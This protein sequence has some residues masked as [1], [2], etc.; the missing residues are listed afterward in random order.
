MSLSKNSCQWAVHTRKTVFCWILCTSEFASWFYLF[1][2]DIWSCFSTVD[3]TEKA[4]NQSTWIFLYVIADIHTITSLTYASS[5]SNAPCLFFTVEGHTGTCVLKIQKVFQ[6]LN[7]APA[8]LSKS[9]T[10]ICSWHG[11]GQ[12]GSLSLESSVHA[13]REK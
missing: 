11:R 8:N 10:G 3:G 7:L 13:E 6:C 4:H 5:L 1:S 9:D 12:Q 2:N